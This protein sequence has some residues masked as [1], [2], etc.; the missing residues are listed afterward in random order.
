MNGLCFGV[1]MLYV[2]HGTY[3]MDKPLEYYYGS[4]SHIECVI[5]RAWLYSSY[6]KQPFGL[7]CE[8]RR[9]DNGMS[10]VLTDR[11]LYDIWACTK[12]L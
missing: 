10:V 4:N 7:W 5:D 11:E 1:Y 3:V 8:Y 9:I 2:N 12:G 6:G